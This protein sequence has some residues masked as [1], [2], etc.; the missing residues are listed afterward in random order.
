[1]PDTPGMISASISVHSLQPLTQALRCAPLAGGRNFPLPS[2]GADDYD[3][4]PRYIA[5]LLGTT[6][7]R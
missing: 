7:N 1:M 5:P 3:R 6:I 4:H 2:V